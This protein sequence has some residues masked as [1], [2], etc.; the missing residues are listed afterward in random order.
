MRS[1]EARADCGVEAIEITFTV[2]GAARVIAKILQRFTRDQIVVATVLDPE[3]ARAATPSGAQFVVSS[4]L[5]PEAARLCNRY[6]ILYIPGAS[7]PQRGD[8]G[9][10]V[11]RRYREGLSGRSP[12]SSPCEARRYKGSFMPTGGV[13]L[14]N[15][16]DWMQANGVAVGVGGSVT[17]GTKQGVFPTHHRDLAAV[18]RQNSPAGWCLEVSVN[19][20]TSNARGATN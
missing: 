18:H 19:L 4:S 16:G 9:N 12:L 17:A 5:N 2:L 8:R 10:G 15:V 6:Q 13:T 14:E 3:T 11:W 20:L 1:A 7:T